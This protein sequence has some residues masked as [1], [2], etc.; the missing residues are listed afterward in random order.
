V[1]NGG[2]PDACAASNE[3]AD[4]PRAGERLAG[5]WW[6]LNG[7]DGVVQ[8][9]GDTYGEL[10]GAL[11]R[12]RCERPGTKARRPTKQQFSSG[13]VPSSAWYSLLHH[14][15]A[16]PQ[17]R[18]SQDLGGRASARRRPGLTA[19]LKGVDKTINT[20]L[21]GRRGTSR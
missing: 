10:D 20:R 21:H 6:A 18:L 16:D 4:H 2:D 12:G 7:Q 15:V 5:P 9:G 1:A 19:P 17:Q 14:V 11:T 3:L 8:I 13:P